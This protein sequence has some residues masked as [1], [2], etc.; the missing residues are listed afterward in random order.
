MRPGD[1]EI[2]LE[3]LGREFVPAGLD[4]HKSGPRLAPRDADEPVRKHLLV[5]EH[6]GDFDVAL[7]RPQVHR[8]ASERGRIPSPSHDCE[9]SRRRSSL[10]LLGAIDAGCR[11]QACR[12]PRLF[13]HVAPPVCSDVVKAPYRDLAWRYYTF[14]DPRA[15]AQ[16]TAR[17]PNS[18]ARANWS[19]RH[20]YM[21]ATARAP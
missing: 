18:I 4:L 19:N 6:E 5:A 15:G 20:R 17:I 13:G 1:V 8:M 10:L 14:A 21:V 2:V 9:E 11:N 12:M 16:S 7:Y 3:L